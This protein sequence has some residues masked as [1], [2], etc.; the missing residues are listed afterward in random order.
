MKR[1]LSF[2]FLLLILF[3]PVAYGLNFYNDDINSEAVY[4][5]N[6]NSTTPIIEKNI[7]QRRSPASLTKIMT[8]IVA[9][10]NIKDVSN[11][12]IKVRQE[13]VDMVDPESSGCELKAGEE[14]TALEL[15]HCMMICS[16]GWAAMVLADYAG[17]GVENFVDLMNKKAQELGCKDTYFKNPDGFYDSE[18]YTTAEDM[19]KITKYAMNLPEFLNITGKSEYSLFNDKRDPIVT[20]N[21]MIDKKRGGDYYLPYVKGIKTG[22][23]EEAGK[24]LI[25]YAEK[26]GE[27]YVAVVMGGPV[28]DKK[29]ARI[30]KN[31]AMIDTKKIYKWVFENLVSAKLYSKDSPLK[32]IDLK[33]VWNHDKLLVYPQ[34]D[35]YFSLP[36]NFSKDD[37]R[38]SFNVKDF[39]EAP[40]EAGDVMGTAEIFYKDEKIGDFNVV[41]SQTFNKN[42]LLV[43]NSFFCGLFL[44]PIS[45]IVISLVILF[46]VFYIFAI[47]KGNKRRKKRRRG[48]VKVFSGYRNRKKY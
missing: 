16:S 1:F 33:Y 3:N 13:V 46:L 2:I 43:F 25:S 48:N 32:E 39:V 31:L 36:K 26:N 6:K 38:I 47:L 30:E 11:Y 21:K 4:V 35:F 8:Y 45:T 18:Q 9:C 20:T 7:N 22:Y 29:G 41:S 37:I 23:L 15:F 12:K 17:G 40:V 34:S 5:I 10:E 24:C 27:T 14:F 42:Y 44:S 28:V 19:Y